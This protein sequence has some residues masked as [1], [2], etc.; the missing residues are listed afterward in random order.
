MKLTKNFYVATATAFMFVLGMS[1]LASCVKDRDLDTYAAE[2]AT[3]ALWAFDDV[4]NIANEASRLN[5]GEHLEHY[6][7][8]GY[9]SRIVKTPGQIIVAF[10]NENGADLENC[11]CTD[12]RNRRGKIIINYTGVYNDSG[13]T[14]TISFEDYFVDD[15]EMRGSETVRFMGNNNDG[16]PYLDVQVDGTF[17]ILD[18]LGALTYKGDITRTWVQGSSTIQFSD[19]IYELSGTGQGVNIYGNNYAFNALEPIVKPTNLG[20]RYF[21][22]GILEVQPQGRTF[23]SIDFGDG[24]CD[25]T[26]TVTIDRKQNN[27]N[28]R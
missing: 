6:K 11:L 20:C 22:Q 17:D 9:C 18:S 13:E 16:V 3:F 23:R 24:T 8:A 27:I 2:D 10:G 4:I 26:A 12:G 1:L 15:N 5:D 25:A 7:T 14:V 21:T 28:L 19:D